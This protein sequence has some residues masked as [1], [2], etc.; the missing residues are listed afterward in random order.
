MTRPATFLSALVLFLVSGG[1]GGG[2]SMLNNTSHSIGTRTLQTLTV[3]PSSADARNSPNGQVQFMATGTFT[4]S[5]MTVPSPPVRWSIGNPFATPTP[6][7]SISM[8]SQ[9]SIDG[10]GLAQCNGS[11]GIATIVATAPVDPNVSLIQLTA[12]TPNVSGRASLICP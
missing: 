12:I 10:N 1:C 11:V 9:P 2:S 5:P 8:S 3:T 4:T 7:I 6:A